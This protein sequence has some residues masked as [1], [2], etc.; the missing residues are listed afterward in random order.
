MQ[1]WKQ[2]W[3]VPE[4]ARTQGRRGGA[5][6]ACPR[7]VL[8]E[9]RS[10]IIWSLTGQDPEWKLHPLKLWARRGEENNGSHD[11]ITLVLCGIKVR[12]A[13]LKTQACVITCCVTLRMSPYLSGPISNMSQLPPRFSVE[14]AD[15]ILDWPN[16]SFGFFH[17][18]VQRNVNEHFIQCNTL[19]VQCHL[20]FAAECTAKLSLIVLRHP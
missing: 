12:N 5:T 17:T 19:K 15:D 13:E 14:L 9:N 8:V 3:Y 6:G 7:L 16:G 2:A 20:K 1:W 11:V 4:T 18:M 10:H